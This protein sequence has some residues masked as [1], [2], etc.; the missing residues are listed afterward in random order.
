MRIMFRYEFLKLK[1]VIIE[2][3]AEVNI[4][5]ESGTVLV[6]SNV[7]GGK[8]NKATIKFLVGEQDIEKVKKTIFFNGK[9]DFTKYETYYYKIN[10]RY[11]TEDPW[12]CINGPEKEESHD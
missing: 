4:S 1:G 11:T 6:E 9:F 8:G 5:E 2:D 10:E 12:V 3:V 7:F